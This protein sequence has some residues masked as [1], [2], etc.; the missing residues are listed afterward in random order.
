MEDCQNASSIGLLR[1]SI[2]EGLQD[3]SLN[4]IPSGWLLDDLQEVVY[5]RR[6]SRGVQNEQSFRRSAINTF[7]KSFILE[8]LLEI[9]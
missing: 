4:R 6:P 3:A 1:S 2:L 9:C 7:K 8:D 5:N